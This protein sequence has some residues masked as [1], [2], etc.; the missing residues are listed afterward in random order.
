MD[1]EALRTFIAIHRSGTVT[2]A[3][4]A[5]FRSQPAVSRRLALLEKELDVPLFERVPGGVVLSEAGR[6]LLPF[7][8]AV[9][10][11]VRDAEAAVRAVRSQDSGPVTVALVGT[12]AST[13]LTS[14]LRRF[15]Q[16]YP[17]V[18]LTL[19]TATSK[20]V[21]DLVRRADVTVGLRYSADPAPELECETLYSER[22]VIAAPPERAGTRIATLSALAGERW[23][24]FPERPGDA[25]SGSVRRVM[26]AAG[27][28]ESQILR[29]DSLTAQKRLVEAG[30]GI[31]LVPDSSIQEELAAGSLVALEVGDLDVGLPVTLVT[32]RGGYLS[33]ATRTLLAELRRA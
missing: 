28:P 19:R 2:G 9:L 13:N 29:I 4:A 14:V 21:S 18:E 27:V 31:A 24:A 26:D 23:L 11:S 1:I 25:S 17:A 6:A 5:V 10:A 15:A 7:A 8:E 12:L 32:R 33:A 20:E 30:F 22:L 3:A 16:R